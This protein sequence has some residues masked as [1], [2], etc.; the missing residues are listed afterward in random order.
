[1]VRANGQRDGVGKPDNC[2]VPSST[3]ERF[4]TRP[5][6]LHTARGGCYAAINEAGH[7]TVTASEPSQEMSSLLKQAEALA[8]LRARLPAHGHQRLS[9]RFAGPSLRSGPCG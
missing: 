1:M 4:W 9:T 8:A 6:Y 7:T 5:A 3:L 2:Q